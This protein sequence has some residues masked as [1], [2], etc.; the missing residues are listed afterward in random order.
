MDSVSILVSLFMIPG[1]SQ[2]KPMNVAISTRGIVIEDREGEGEVVR[3]GYITTF[4][5]DLVNKA[6]KV[7]ASTV[8][9]GLPFTTVVDG[10]STETPLFAALRGMKKGGVRRLIATSDTIQ[11]AREG[12]VPKGALLTVRVRVVDVRPPLIAKVH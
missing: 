4:H 8:Q 10:T 3:D 5:Y 9:R 2:L 6:G 11:L 1:A 12:M 7:L